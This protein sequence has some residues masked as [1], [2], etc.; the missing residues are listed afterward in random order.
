MYTITTLLLALAVSTIAQITVTPGGSCGTQP[1]IPPA[2]RNRFELLTVPDHYI[3]GG[4]VAPYSGLF[5]KGIGQLPSLSN[6]Q[7]AATIFKFHEP[8]GDIYYNY[9]ET[10]SAS[11]PLNIIHLNTIANLVATDQRKE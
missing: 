7:S 1:G 8:T 10:V 6:N 5:L 4:N 3:S 11:P 9:Q 2:G